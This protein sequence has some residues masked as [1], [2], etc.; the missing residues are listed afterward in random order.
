[1]V[2]I[3]RSS[4]GN[5]VY[6]FALREYIAYLVEKRFSLQFYI[7]GTRSRTGK[8]QPPRLGLLTYVVE[9]YHEGRS[10]DLV[11]VPVSIAYDQLQEVGN[12]AR[13][14]R[15]ASKSAESIGWLVRAFREQ[16]GRYGRI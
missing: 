9:A 13:E 6:R 8:L 14:A 16:R 12:Y 2:Y 11:L 10:D 5:T 15:G 4:K 1:I 3:R 7:E